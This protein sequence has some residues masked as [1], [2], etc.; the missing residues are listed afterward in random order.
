VGCTNNQREDAARPRCSVLHE[1]VMAGAEL[2]SPLQPPST[3]AG[4]ANGKPTPVASPCTHARIFTII[5]VR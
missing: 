1:L 5:R 3:T 2:A 4:V